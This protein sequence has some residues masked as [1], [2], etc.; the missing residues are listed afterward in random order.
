ME[1]LLYLGK[2]NV[3]WILFYACYWLLFRKHTFFVWNRA[4]LIGTLLI[5]FVLPWVH[6]PESEQIL[7]STVLY[8][9][10][11]N[12]TIPSIIIP[13]QSEQQ[14][15]DWI[16]LLW[17]I[18]AFGAIYMLKRLTNSF[19]DLLKIIRQGEAVALPDCTLILLPH[20]KIGSFSFLKWL[21]IN[22]SD[23]QRHP[24]PIIRHEMV[25]IR[26]WHSLDILLIEVLKVAFWFNPV[27]WFYKHSMQE[28]HEFLADEQAPDRD[29]YARF[30]VTYSLSAPVAALTNHFFNSSILKN[31]IKM[32]YKNRNSKWSL[33]KYLVIAPVVFLALTL[34]AAREKIFEES[35]NAKIPAVKTNARDTEN[36]KPFL[37]TETVPVIQN[38]DMIT[39][40]GDVT[41]ESGAGISGANVFINETTT[42]TTTDPVGHFKL[43]DIPV[44][45]ILTVR[46]VGYDT[47]TFA[48]EI[49]K[50]NYAVKLKKAVNELSGP[51]FTAYQDI[52]K[53]KEQREK[54][55]ETSQ[56]LATIPERQPEFPGGHEEMLKYIQSNIK[57]PEEAMGVTVDGIA[58]VSFTVNSNGN[59]R[60]PKVVKEIGYGIDEEAIRVVLNMPRWEPARQNGK[61]VSMEYTL[62]IHFKIE[63][64]K[65][66]RQGYNY[67]KAEMDKAI[68][69]KKKGSIA[70][71]KEVG[72]FFSNQ[73]DFSEEDKPKLTQPRYGL[74]SY[75]YSIGRKQTKL[76][77][78]L[79]GK[80]GNIK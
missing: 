18:P 28:I 55:K 60:Q 75:R 62:S 49:G 67:N 6:M 35:E 50:K 14:I 21:V 64:D 42:G 61:A 33:G 78:F 46:Y 12:A 34:T 40:E 20:D 65:G 23:Y 70:S 2:V 16:L 32:I 27:L 26:Q 24:D 59:I 13:M 17:L 77:H 25:H 52:E 8:S 71:M 45:S 29:H 38:Q 73:T 56:A 80:D 63:K 53:I 48:V 47:Q 66:K 51:T 57:Y 7:P 74:V 76:Y 30:L 68:E 54:Q 72:K 3:C 39:I 15:F 41:R 58:L 37:A 43:A 79:S 5:S 4:Y 22:N 10:E 19:T 31:R 1:A 36:K 9:V 11:M 44:G 69:L